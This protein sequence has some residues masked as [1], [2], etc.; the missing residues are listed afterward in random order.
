[1]AKCW[2]CGGGKTITLTTTGTHVLP[3]P[4]CGG[5]GEAPPAPGG[6]GGKAA[7]FRHPEVGAVG[8]AKPPAGGLRRPDRA[9][10]PEQVVQ[11]VVG[12]AA[13][14]VADIQLL[15]HDG[16][17]EKTCET[18]EAHGGLVPSH[19]SASTGC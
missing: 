10:R 13:G 2:R 4:A 5:S 9:V 8:A 12:H 16:P 18:G 17:P 11:V 6:E 19:D 15:S 1:M 14:Q 7:D 3:C